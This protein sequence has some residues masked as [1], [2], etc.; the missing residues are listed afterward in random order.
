MR[1]TAIIVAALGAVRTVLAVGS[2]SC[3]TFPSD[4]ELNLQSPS[5]CPHQK[6]FPF[7]SAQNGAGFVIAHRSSFTSVPI[8]ID[9]E[10]DEAVHVAVKSFAEDI[11]R[12]T[13]VLPSI[14]N[15]SLPS[16]LS[17]SNAIVVSTLNTR[18]SKDVT[19]SQSLGLD[20]M[21][22]SYDIRVVGEGDHSLQGL[23]T[24][25]SITG[26]DR[27]SLRLC[28]VFG[29]CF[30]GA[31]IILSAVSYTPFILSRRKSEFPH[32]T[33][34]QTS[35]PL[36]DPQSYSHRTGSVLTANRASSIV[37]SSSMT[38]Y[39]FYGTSRGITS[40]SRGL[41]DRSKLGYTR[42]CSS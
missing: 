16:H 29:T 8:L 40:I 36:T 19:T 20:G 9:S 32:G 27:V 41:R 22:E 4:D 39:R 7:P 13:G 37:G 23:G 6:A 25:L 28:K 12:V 2:S 38:K 24:A 31:D 18:T 3:L 10:D 34:G 35:H 21:W 26:S 17:G 33:G 5:T 1:V 30:N 42:K 14:W 15:D 11:E